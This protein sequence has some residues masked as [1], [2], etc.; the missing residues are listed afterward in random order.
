MQSCPKKEHIAA[1]I[2]FIVNGLTALRYLKG[3]GVEA[4]AKK[5]GYLRKFIILSN[6][7]PCKCPK[8]FSPSTYLCF[9]IY[10]TSLQILRINSIGQDGETLIVGKADFLDKPH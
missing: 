10:M 7:T 2:E 6:V 8:F 4:I 1:Y 9:N 5:E 3:V